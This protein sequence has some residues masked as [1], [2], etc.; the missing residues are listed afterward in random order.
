MADVRLR[1]DGRNAQQQCLSERK[2]SYSD[3]YEKEID[4]YRSG[5]FRKLYLEPRRQHGCEEICPE[6]WQI[7]RRPGQDTAD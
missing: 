6:L 5:N 2:L 1:Q 4:G 3:K 7:R